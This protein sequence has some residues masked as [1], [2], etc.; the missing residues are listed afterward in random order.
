MVTNISVIFSPTINMKLI[1]QCYGCTIMKPSKLLTNKPAFTMQFCLPLCLI[2]REKK[3][4]LKAQ[5][6]SPFMQ[7][8]KKKGWHFVSLFFIFFIFY[9]LFFLMTDFKCHF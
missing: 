8:K 7:P 5:S 1:G 6:V 2:S 4:Q 9:Y 3:A